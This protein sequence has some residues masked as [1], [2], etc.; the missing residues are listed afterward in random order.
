[1]AGTNVSHNVY[2]R[3]NS[4]I[5]IMIN[6]GGKHLPLN[7][8]RLARCNYQLRGPLNESRPGSLRTITSE[9]ISHYSYINYS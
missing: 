6:D 5:R 8:H 3:I 7:I 9:S 2:K 1:M 4:I